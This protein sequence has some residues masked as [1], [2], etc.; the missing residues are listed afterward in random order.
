MSEAAQFRAGDRVLLLDRAR[1]RYVITLEPG[2][3]FHFHHGHLG[4]DEVIGQPEGTVL[5]SSKGARLIAV[6][7]TLAE[8][9]LEMPRQAQ[10]IYPKDLGAIW[11]AMDLQPGLR[12]FESG[13]GPGALTQVILR[14]IGETGSLTV[15]EAREE[16]VTMGLR[17][18]RTLFGEVP[19]NLHVE[20]R[21]TYQG[22]DGS[23]FDRAFLDLPEPWQAVTAVAGALRPG[24]LVFAHTPTIIQAQQFV[25]AMHRSREF[26]LDET[27]EVLQRPWNIR[28]RSVRPAHRMIGHT[29]FLTF[30]RRISGGDPFAIPGESVAEAD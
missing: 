21:D 24:G 22:I 15:Y 7:A 17:N 13:M 6:R 29:G 9:I 26:A 2:A 5:H 16:F 4:H 8:T 27:I 28:G 18:V 23:G 10:V 20:V 19:A 30:A 25:E 1:R 14:A 11:M 12:V 3:T